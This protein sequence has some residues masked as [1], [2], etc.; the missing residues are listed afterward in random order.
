LQET[1]GAARALRVELQLLPVQDPG[2]FSLEAAFKEAIKRR[3]EALLISDCPQ[4]FPPAQTVD[5]AAKSRLPAIYPFGYYAV[6]FGDLMAYG[7]IKEEMF[8]RAAYFVD[9][10]LRGAKPADLPIE[11]PT[12][13]E[14]VVNLKTAKQLS[15]TIPPTVLMWADKVIE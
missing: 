2:G 10:V 13:F 5:L 8:R 4:A 7:P 9:R 11:Q 6:D 15:L 1:K 12:K 14:L 3:S